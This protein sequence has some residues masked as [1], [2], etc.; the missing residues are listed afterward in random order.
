MPTEKD[1]SSWP[2]LISVIVTAIMGLLWVYSGT[3]NMPP[4]AQSP[5]IAPVDVT[6]GRARATAV[7]RE[8]CEKMR[9]DIANDAVEFDPD[10]PLDVAIVKAWAADCRSQHDITILK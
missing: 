10:S 6:P 3:R 8:F 1:P 9:R 7:A 4:V 2:L 5:T